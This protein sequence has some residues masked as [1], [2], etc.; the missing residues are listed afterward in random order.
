M[1]DISSRP[2]IANKVRN[3]G[4][5]KYIFL[6]F[7]IWWYREPSIIDTPEVIAKYGTIFEPKTQNYEAIKGDISFKNVTFEYIEGETAL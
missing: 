5:Y 6:G 2:K 3:F 7:P 1:A 4:E